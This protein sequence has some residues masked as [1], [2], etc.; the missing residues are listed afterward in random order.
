MKKSVLSSISLMFICLFVLNSC[1]N[2]QGVNLFSI[3]EDKRLGLKLKDE[4]TSKP[5]EYPILD[6]EKYRTT[7]EYLHR[8][9]DSILNSGIILY[10]DEFAWELKIIQD[11]SVLN[12]FCAPGGYIYVYTGLL[13]FLDSEDQ[14]AGVLA[15]E[16]AHA[17][18]RHSTE[19]LT[20]SYG[21][22]LLLRVVLG[23]D[24]AILGDIARGLISLK[25]SRSDEKE[26]DEYSVKYL[27]ETNYNAAGAAGFFEKLQ[28][29]KEEGYFP[30]FLSTHPSSDDR[31]EKINE[32]K[33]AGGC[34]GTKTFDERYEEL[35][36]ILP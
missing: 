22:S 15:H 21:V 6:E 20:K 23:N 3:K 34:G 27:C 32:H 10:K 8:I 33:T 16:I 31:V 24:I 19:Q 17:D 2:N 36:S 18:K 13:K 26:A 14:L 11:D 25:F 30:E 35:K 12:A 28:E 29:K 5:D 1:K 4:I 7:Y 9:R